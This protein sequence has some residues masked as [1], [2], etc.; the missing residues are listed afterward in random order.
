MGSPLNSE[1]GEIFC[2]AGESGCGKTTTGRA[3]VRLV[4]P[5][6]GT[7]EYDGVN[8]AS[9][10]NRE[11]KEYRRRL[12][13]I[14]QDPYS[15][16]NPR[17]TVRQIVAEPVNVHR[18]AQSAGDLRDRVNRAL[19]DAGLAPPGEFLDRYPHELSGG[20]QQRVAIA[21]AL[22]LE[23]DFIVADEPVSML[24]VSVRSE[25]LRL[26]L[27]LRERTHL[28][29]LFVTHDLSLAWLI[30]DRIGIMYLGRIVELGRADE[31][32]NRPLHPYTKALVSVIPVP[33]PN[34]RERERTI[35]EG[36]PPN[37]ALIPSGCRF[38][39]RCPVSQDRC[40][41]EEPELR[42]LTY[43]HYAACH[44]A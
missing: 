7:I 2:L 11:M 13:I 34:T 1:R 9:L 20:Q 10:S 5:T 44:Y 27:E 33:N 30:A 43:G 31:L 39:P 22:V 14:F 41:G 12:Q 37:P 32:I 24:D 25:I 40:K 28:T 36:D 35:L 19:T 4:R 8:L 15:S 6:V 18:L 3:L 26:M 38:H 42:E 29:Y 21:G 23:P 16:L 17:Q